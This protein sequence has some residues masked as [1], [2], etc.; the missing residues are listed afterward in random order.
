MPEQ[1]KKPWCYF[2]WT[3]WV[4]D[5][6][7][8]SRR[9][10]LEIHPLSREHCRL[11][12]LTWWFVISAGI[13]ESTGKGWYTIHWLRPRRFRILLVLVLPFWKSNEFDTIKLAFQINNHSLFLSYYQPEALG[14]TRLITSE[15]DSWWTP[16]RWKLN[17]LPKTV[18]DR[19]IQ[20]Q[21]LTFFR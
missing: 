21:P 20:V 18:K 4:G 5:L 3:D 6:C 14:A 12:C 2:Y 7:L 11:R 8:L 16:A 19:D 10:C 15:P 9:R 17:D 13:K 1:T